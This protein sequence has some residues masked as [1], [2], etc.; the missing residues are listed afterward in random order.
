M[1]RNLIYTVEDNDPGL[2]WVHEN[3]A[4]LDFAGAMAGKGIEYLL[5]PKEGKIDFM[6]AHNGLFSLDRQKLTRFNL[7]P[8]VMCSTRQ[9]FTVVE[10]GKKLAGCRA[11][12]L[13]LARSDYAKAMTVLGDEP[14][15]EVLRLRQAKVGILVTGTEVFQGL[16]EDKF[17]PII[18][19]KVEKLGC[20]VASYKIVPDDQKAIAAAVSDLLDTGAD[21]LVT[22]AGLSVDPEDVTLK[23]I[24]E[25]GA[26]DLLYGAPILP[27]AMTMIGRIGEAQVFG[28]PA[29]A[30][31]YK[32]TSFDLLLP[33]LLAG[34]PVTRLDLAQMAEG[35]YCLSCKSCTFPKCPFGR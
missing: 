8:N 6:A 22:T 32:A 3:E 27:G 13:Y 34:L 19:S 28:V 17:F 15:L 5:P 2:E 26:K 35:G 9:N 25:A 12:P 31:F 14:L 29:C 20:T 11:L 24:L 7:V 33:R 10:K 23:G 4:V 30:L 18:R 1:G 21:L 16:V